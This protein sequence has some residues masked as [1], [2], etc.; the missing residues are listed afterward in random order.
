MAAGGR[1]SGPGAGCPG[2]VPDVQGARGR[3]ELLAHG[4]FGAKIRRILLRKLGKRCGKARSTRG[5]A[6][7]W[8]KFNK[9]LPN[10]QI[11]ENFL[12]L[13]LWGIFRNWG[14]HDKNKLE[15]RVWGS[16]IVINLALDTKMV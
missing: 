9:I 5:T 12:G 3:D 2:H 13:F 6:N 16:K 8:N 4:D 11:T 1:M 15:D 7:P 10:Q 14:E